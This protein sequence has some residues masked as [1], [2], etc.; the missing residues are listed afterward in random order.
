MRCPPH[1]CRS[2]RGDR[3]VR[4]GLRSRFG[5]G[6][7]IARLATLAALVVIVALGLVG[8]SSDP[9]VSNGAPPPVV[10]DAPVT[11]VAIGGSE[12]VNRGLG[13]GFRRSWTG[14]VFSSLP[15][16]TVFANLAADG[17]TVA[18]SLNDQVPQAVSLKPTVVTVWFARN[19]SDA[20]TSSASFTRDLTQ[21]ATQL[22]A[23][24]ARVLLLSRP[25][26]GGGPFATSTQ[27]VA[28]ATG[29]EF[30]LLPAAPTPEQRRDPA[31]Q[32]SIAATV[33]AKLK[34]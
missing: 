33:A 24:G 10:V 27:N 3:K 16:S 11:Y 32:T 13:D 2:G 8:C 31:A 22:K 17:S 12:T 29:T 7:G 4:V 6:I 30:V 19:D 34:P 28:Q 18:G 20:R 26:D 21:V 23:S 14:Q 9:P 15:R 5:L 25:A 1:R